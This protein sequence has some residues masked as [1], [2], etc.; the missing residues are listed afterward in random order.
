MPGLKAGEQMTLQLGDREFG[1]YVRGG[2]IL[3]IL[4]HDKEMSLLEAF[5]NS[6]TLQVYLDHNTMASGYIYL[7]DGETVNNESGERTLMRL[8]Y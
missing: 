1:I 4:N 8:T 2:H 5:D 3:P 7:D 6:V